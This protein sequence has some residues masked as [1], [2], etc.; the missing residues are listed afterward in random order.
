MHAHD[1]AEAL[2]SNDERRSSMSDNVVVVIH[3][4]DAEWHCGFDCDSG[5]VAKL[6]AIGGG[7]ADA[8]RKQ[9]RAAFDEID[10]VPSEHAVLFCEAAGT[11]TV[12]RDAIGSFLLDELG[13]RALQF[14]AA[15]LLAI[16]NNG[17]DTGVLVDVGTHVVH[18]YMMYAGVAV[19]D[20]AAAHSLD[21]ATDPP[22]SRTRDAIVRTIALAD[23][24]LREA[25]L[26]SVVL[27][28]IG[29]MAADF[30]SKLEAQLASALRGSVWRPRVKANVDRRYASW[31]GGV[32]FSTLPSAQ[33]LFLSADEYKA[34]GAARLHER[35]TPLGSKELGAL[36]LAHATAA[37]ARVEQ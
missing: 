27:V 25:L 18:V 15:P 7:G 20:T 14:A 6:P 16:Y 13:V 19:L 17:F 33:R 28:G 12:E 9:L 2:Q 22:V 34:G 10:A 30:P 26:A 23:L 31:L 3:A 24:S 37:R 1:T 35:A 5:P 4:G 11:S 8:M 29:S 36:E 32:V 21:H